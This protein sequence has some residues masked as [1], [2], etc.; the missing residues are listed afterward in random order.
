MTNAEKQKYISDL[1]EMN[2]V[3]FQSLFIQLIQ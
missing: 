1:V 3:R 2:A